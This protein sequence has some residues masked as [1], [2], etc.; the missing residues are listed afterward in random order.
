MR[1]QLTVFQRGVLE[2]LRNTQYGALADAAEAAWT[3]A[4]ACHDAMPMG[5]PDLIADF[6]KANAQLLTGFTD[7][8]RSR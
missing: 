2:R 3:R 8:R 5:E 6:E 4:E 7:R 1:R